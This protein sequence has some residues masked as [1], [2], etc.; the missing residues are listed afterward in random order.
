MDVQPTK[1]ASEVNN[2]F[3]KFLAAKDIENS[4]QKIEG[5]SIL[6]QSNRSLLNLVFSGLSA[7]EWSETN[8]ILTDLRSTNILNFLISSVL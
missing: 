4:R 8:K 2:Q 6:V 3:A 1:V 7:S 5:I